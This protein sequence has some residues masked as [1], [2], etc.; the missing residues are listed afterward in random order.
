MPKCRRRKVDGKIA[1]L[2]DRDD[3]VANT[4]NTFYSLTVQCARCHDHKFDP[5]SQEDYYG[6]QAVFAALDRA[7]RTYDVGPMSPTGATPWR[8][9]DAKC[10]RCCGRTP[11]SPPANCL[12]S[13][14]SW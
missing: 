8:T 6:L 7:D 11:L 2:L 3:M 4:F 1:R 5:I 13:E 14:P 12:A 9:V 10:R